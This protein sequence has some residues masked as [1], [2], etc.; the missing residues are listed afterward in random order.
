MNIKFSKFCKTNDYKVSFTDPA[1]PCEGGVKT[2]LTFVSCLHIHQRNLL[3][4]RTCE[5]FVLFAP[6]PRSKTMFTS[7]LT[8]TRTVKGVSD[9]PTL[10][11]RISCPVYVPRCLVSLNFLEWIESVCFVCFESVWRWICKWRWSSFSG[12]KRGAVRKVEE[13]DGSADPS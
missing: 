2:N 12:D 13:E 4:R 1:L 10:C 3:G 6:L 9:E 8:I 5:H 11:Y 7:A